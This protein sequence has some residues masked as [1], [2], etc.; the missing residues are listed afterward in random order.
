M[1]EPIREPTPQEQRTG[2]TPEHLHYVGP[3]PTSEVGP[4]NVT[5]LVEWAPT[6]GGVFVALGVLLLLSALG[7]AIGVSSGATGVV[8]WE[9]ISM[10]IAFFVGGWFTGRTLS[11]IDPLVAGAHGLLV[12]AVSVVFTI[13]FFIT[14]TFA[15]INALANLARVPFIAR[16]LD[17]LG[18]GPAPAAGAAA[19]A[20]A[21]VTSSWAT[22]IILL[23]AVIA[24]VI[25]ALV[26]ASS[27]VSAVTE[28]PH[29]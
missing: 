2:R 21:A 15:G 17:I 23:L 19:S 27:R 20:T 28:V 11:L 5:G 3:V 10:I 13:L 6:W 12:W 14:A 18:L 9:A 4:F 1:R 16:L 24:S 8:I 22:F 29:R 25:G 26:A 7:V